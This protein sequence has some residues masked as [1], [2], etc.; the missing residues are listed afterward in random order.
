MGAI[1]GEASGRTVCLDLDTVKCPQA[2][3]W[4]Q[5]VLTVESY[6]QE[7]ET[8]KAVSGSGGRHLF[9]KYPPGFAMP[10]SKTAIGVDVR[11]QGGFIVLAPTV[12]NN[13]RAYAWEDGFAPWQTDLATAPEWLIVAIEELIRRHGGGGNGRE[14]TA[15]GAEFNSFG[16]RVDGRETYMAET[17]LGRARSTVTASGTS[18]ARRPP[19]RS[20]NGRRTPSRSTA[21]TSPHACRRTDQGRRTG[22]SAR[23][24]AGPPSPPSGAPLSGSG[25]TAIAEEAKKPKDDPTE[26]QPQPARPAS[27]HTAIHVPALR[28]ARAAS[29]PRRQW[30]YGGTS[31]EAIC[32][33]LW[34]PARPARRRSPSPSASTW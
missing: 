17:R 34:R 30:L 28:L 11:G 14:R 21:T 26:E 5:G 32:R 12:H 4:W 7:P 27:R 25:T 10:T 29:L 19:A 18:Q 22:S 31:F 6:G 9:F 2:A 20:R 1:L 16:R 23:A 24:A 13:G 15:S 33:F 8:W 3:T